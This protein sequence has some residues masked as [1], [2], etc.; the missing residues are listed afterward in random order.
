MSSSDC[1]ILFLL[2]SCQEIAHTMTWECFIITFNNKYV[3]KKKRIISMRNIFHSEKNIKKNFQSV[4]DLLHSL[5]RPEQCAPKQDSFLSDTSKGGS[6]LP[7]VNRHG[8]WRGKNLTCS[9]CWKDTLGMLT[10][11]RS[12]GPRQPFT[13]PLLWCC[14]LWGSDSWTQHGIYCQ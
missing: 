1:V 6:I 10:L 14:Y 2:F 11:L 8:N 4:T 9:G 13:Y 12:T 5:P 3:K 7:E